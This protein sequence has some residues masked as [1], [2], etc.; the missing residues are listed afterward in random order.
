MSRE[1]AVRLCSFCNNEFFADPREIKRGN[2]KFCSVVCY[3]NS[4]ARQ[5]RICAA[6]HKPFLV[7]RSEIRKGNG[8]FCSTKCYHLTTTPLIDRFFK[9]V[10]RKLPNGCIPW[11][12]CASKEGYG[13]INSGTR[14]GRMLRASHV[15]YELFIGPIPN[16][17]FVL[18]RCDW[19]ACIKPTHLFLGTQSDNM[20]DKVAKDRSAKGEKARHAKLTAVQVSE[21]RLRYNTDNDN[22]HKLAKEYGVTVGN[23]LSIINRKTWKHV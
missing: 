3:R 16:N 17:L 7:Y 4:R 1:L 15:S 10:G 14:Q 2:A 6:C 9:Y 12:G 18:H 19:P 5:T 11:I 13:V 20:A 22:R 8:R 21:I 23:I